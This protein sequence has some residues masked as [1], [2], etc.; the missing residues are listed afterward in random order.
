LNQS[1]TDLFFGA[2]LKMWGFCGDLDTIPCI[3]LIASDIGFETKLKRWIAL[4]L[5]AVLPGPSK[6][7][8]Q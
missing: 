6:P 3:F 1:F 2:P 4:I 7:N 5:N 8:H